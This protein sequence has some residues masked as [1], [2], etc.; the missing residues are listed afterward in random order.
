MFKTFMNCEA[1]IK[2]MQDFTID[3]FFGPTSMC[4]IGVLYTQHLCL[5][6]MNP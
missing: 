5:N 6:S 2:M 1:H 3:D 4:L